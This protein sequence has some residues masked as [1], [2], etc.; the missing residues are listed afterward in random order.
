MTQPLRNPMEETMADLTMQQ[1]TSGWGHRLGEHCAMAI[2]DL[3][4]IYFALVMGTGI[5]GIALQLLQ[6]PRLSLALFLINAVAYPLLV[7]ASLIRLAAFRTEFITDLM[8]PKVLFSFFTFVAGSN[9]LGTQCYIRGYHDAALALWVIGSLAWLALIYYSFCY[10]TFYNNHPIEEVVNGGWLVSVVGTQSVVVLGTFIAPGLTGLTPDILF[11]L[12]GLWGIGI[13]LYTIFITFILYRLFFKRLDPAELM[14]PYWINMGATAISTLAGANLY[15]RA[16]TAFL[17]SLQ[18]SMAAVSVVL[19][20]WCTW[21][22]P[23]LV[24]LYFWRHVIHKVP[25]RYHPAYWSMVF[26]LGMYTAATYRLSAVLGINLLAPIAA[27]FIWIAVFVWV[28]TM[29][30]LLGGFSRVLVKMAKP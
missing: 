11:V 18:P 30:G 20:A 14:P 16:P 8:N 4:P 15:Q 25:I 1:K 5:I 19:W 3:N 21:W 17:H 29:L 28:L 2:R 6:F 7:I 9:V 23:L 24:A 12:Y 13:L 26:P 27:W 10:L 22:L